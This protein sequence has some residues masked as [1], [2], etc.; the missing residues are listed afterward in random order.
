[1]M[2][3]CLAVV[4]RHCKGRASYAC[5]VLAHVLL[6]TLRQLTHSRTPCS[7]RLGTQALDYAEELFVKA[8]ADAD[9]VMTVQDLQRVLVDVR[10]GG[11]GKGGMMREGG[12]A[13]MRGQ[14]GLTR[15]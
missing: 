9:G 10:Q 6:L 11:G 12:R 7:P 15:R 14:R 8:D 1:M 3:R 13:L 2:E 5:L 4:C